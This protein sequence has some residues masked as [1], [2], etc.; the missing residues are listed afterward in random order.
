MDKL[1]LRAEVFRPTACPYKSA[2]EPYILTKMS[3]ANRL[4]M[5]QIV[6]SMW[7]TIAGAVAE[8]RDIAPAQL[9]QLTDS[10]SVSLSE[11]ALK[12]GFVDGVVYEDQMDDVFAQWG[13]EADEDGEY[14]FVTLGD[15][16]A[17]LRPDPKRLIAPQVAVVYASGQ[18]V[19]GE[20]SGE[21]I[22]GNTLDAD[23]GRST[24]R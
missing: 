9:Q 10:L 4:Q 13:V 3:D 12:Y 18:I 7:G 8:A 15:Y 17:Q 11:D 2:V 14:R 16:V 20:G 19:D 22:Y 24:E 23:S 21:E 1:D 6:D 5:Q